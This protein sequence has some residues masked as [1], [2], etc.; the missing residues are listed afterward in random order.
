MFSEEHF[1]NQ[2]IQFVKVSLHMKE[3]YIHFVVLIARLYF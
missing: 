1:C 3:F 2:E